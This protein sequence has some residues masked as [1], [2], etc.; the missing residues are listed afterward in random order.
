[1]KMKKENKVKKKKIRVYTAG[2]WDLFHVGHLNILK[3][4]RSLGDELIAGVSTDEL[5][6]SYKNQFPAIPFE[7]RKAMLNNCKYVDKVVKQEKLLDPKQLKKLNIDILTIGDDWKNKYMEGL[8]W[9]KKQKNIKVIYLPYTKNISSTKIKENIKSIVSLKNKNVLVTGASSGIGASIAEKFAKCGANVGIHYSSNHEGAQ[10]VFK[11]LSKYTFVKIYKQDFSKEQPNIIKRFITDFG[12]IDILIN[13][14]GM[15]DEKSFLE[16]SSNDYDKIF[17]INSK[18]PF[19]LSRDAFLEMKKKRFGK[20]ISIGSN[21]VKFGTG[22]NG[23]IQYAAAKSTLE[24]LTKGLAK[25]GAE[26]NIIANCIRPGVV[27]TKMQEKRDDYLNRVNLIP[28]K[29]MGSVDDISNL[30]IYL[31]SDAGSYITGQ[32]INVTGGE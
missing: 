1:M 8:E 26:Y 2:T 25:F 27:K 12:T 31:C 24:V 20:I 5:V 4:S 29:R 10:S 18:A 11:E 21:V 3:K 17:K 13:N 7:Y 15:I 28:L 19:F 30:V 22:R 23:S 32:I 6:A 14:A 16:I 9:A